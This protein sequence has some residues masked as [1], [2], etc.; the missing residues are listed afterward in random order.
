MLNKPPWDRKTIV[1]DSFVLFQIAAIAIACATHDIIT[2][3]LSWPK[4]Y[5]EEYLCW[6]FYEYKTPDGWYKGFDLFITISSFL[7][8][9][10]IGVIAE[11]AHKRGELSAK[12]MILCFALTGTAY[13]LTH[14]ALCILFE[15]YYRYWSLLGPEFLGIALLVLS[16][17][18]ERNRRKSKIHT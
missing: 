5:T 8:T 17:I 12:Q 4:E 18:I 6:W 1:R 10:A 15:H 7:I 2:I 3:E 9:V 16:E 11:I 14:C 13:G